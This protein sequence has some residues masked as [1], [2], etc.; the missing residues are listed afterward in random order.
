MHEIVWLLESSG[1][2][3]RWELVGGY[4]ATSREAAQRSA[5]DLHNCNPAKRYRCVSYERTAGD[6]CETCGARA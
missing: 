4:T 2:D 3:D 5:D 1:Q 6:F